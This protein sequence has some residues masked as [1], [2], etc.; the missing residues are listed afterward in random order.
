MEHQQLWIAVIVQ[1]I[2]DACGKFL[3]SN[4]R[5]SRY[6]QEAKEWMGGKD[7]NLVCSLAGLQPNQVTETYSDI[8]NYSHDHY[9]TT[10][11]IRRL[12]NETFSRRSIL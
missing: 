11:D 6:Q 10:E 1:G 8:S 5:N 4:K 12:L 9:L 2:T 7:F 3:W